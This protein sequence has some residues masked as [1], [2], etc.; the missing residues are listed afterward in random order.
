MEKIAIGLAFVGALCIIVSV[1]LWLLGAK[2]T[3]PAEKEKADELNT[4]K[5]ALLVVGGVLLLGGGYA[6]HKSKQEVNNVEQ[7]TLPP[8][9][10]RSPPRNSDEAPVENPP[11]TRTQSFLIEEGGSSMPSFSGGDSINGSGTFDV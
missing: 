4:V 8:P 11:D 2:N 5:I 3:T 1:I 9:L 6:M 7:P 10:E